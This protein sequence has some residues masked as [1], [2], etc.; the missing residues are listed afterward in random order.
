M[1][2]VKEVNTKDPKHMARYGHRDWL[3]WTDRNGNQLAERKTAD[4]IKR[5]LLDTG[6]QKK[7]Y[8]Y[9]ASTGIG[10]IISWRIG[11]V[12][13]TNAKLGY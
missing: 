4:S 1:G 8:L 3:S 12:M 6:T 7:F 10:H 9:E 11:V 2:M 13:Y 5:A